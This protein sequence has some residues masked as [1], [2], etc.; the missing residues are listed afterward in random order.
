[1]LKLLYSKRTREK[2]TLRTAAN[3]CAP[4]RNP[5]LPM[6]EFSPQLPPLPRRVELPPPAQLRLPWMLALLI[7]L[8]VLWL[9]PTF[10][11][12]IEFARTRG[13]ERAEVESAREQ[14]PSPSMEEIS[15]QF[16]VIA[17]AIG[18][19]VVHVDTSQVLTGGRR[20]AL[21]QFFGGPR[22]YDVLAGQGSGVVV[23]ES[24]YILTNYHVV[25]NAQEIHVKLND[26][27][28]RPAEIVGLDPLTDL[29]VIKIASG[30]L[31][32]AQWGD[33]DALQAGSLVWAVGNPFGL[34]RSVTF[35]IISAKSRRGLSSSPYQD[36]L[37]TDAAINP[38]NSGG[39]LVD[40]TGRVVGI[41]TAIVG[42]AYQGVGFSIPSV[43]AKE[44]YERLKSSGKVA[45]GFLGVAL[46]DLTPEL[47]KKL[48]L[49][50]TQ[51]AL[52]VE[53]PTGGPAAQAGIQPGDVIIEWNGQA[54]ADATELRLLIGRTA[55]GSQA[56]VVLLRDDENVP[57]EVKV[58]EL[59]DR[60]RM[61]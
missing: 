37:Q 13:R 55:V 21:A 36:F 47:A 12:R 34:D 56:K 61:R 23:D 35:G 30:G 27:E 6:D 59:P 1:M 2:R 26:S 8:V 29:A 9:L 33:S 53:V 5:E 17:K 4:R 60:P 3:L 15:R 42:K 51:G 48:K 40:V 46:D 54:V 19:S 16:T 28:S 31:I 18:P 43:A 39:P 38:G 25:E 52:V 44:V 32:A 45:R 11:E 20:D 22:Q 7:L 49:K 41:N 50:T 14:L 58:G 24:G 57:L 10:V